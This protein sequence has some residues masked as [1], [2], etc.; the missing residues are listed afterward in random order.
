MTD[1]KNGLDKLKDFQETMKEK[2]LN[3]KEQSENG[4][5]NPNAGID[6]WFNSVVDSLK[7][8]L[9]EAIDKATEEPQDK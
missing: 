6:E 4:N 3:Q 1:D 7:S 5:L 9:K 8:G 2:I